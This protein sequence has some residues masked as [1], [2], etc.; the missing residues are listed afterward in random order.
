MA[1]AVRSIVVTGPGLPPE[2]ITMNRPAGHPY[3]D[4]QLPHSV[5]NISSDADIEA[6]PDRASYYFRL[7]EA[8]DG[9]GNLIITYVPKNP[10][11]PYL[12][13]E[14][15]E[16]LFPQLTSPVSHDLSE[17]NPWGTLTATY[18]KPAGH[19]ADWANLTFWG[20]G[21]IWSNNSDG[22]ASTYVFNSSGMWVTPTGGWLNINT[23]DVITGNMSGLYWYFDMTSPMLDTDGDG[24]PDNI[25]NC[26]FVSN[27]D[28]L[29]TNGDGV[30][31]AC[32][33]SLTWTSPVP[34]R[35][36]LDHPGFVGGSII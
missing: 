25:D 14:I 26:P 6:I 31:D 19:N 1:A 9:T 35:L 2:G 8:P 16:S 12:W 20:T 7:Y 23:V 4:P 30:G 29:D 15:T 5:Y 33:P 3:F 34:T 13:S 11:R 18:I 28:Q 36:V 17:A 10:K 22:H 21:G 24:I 32:D 27:P